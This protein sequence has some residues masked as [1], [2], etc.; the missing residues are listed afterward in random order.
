MMGSCGEQLANT[1]T[2]QNKI[3][4]VIVLKISAWNNKKIKQGNE[5]LNQNIISQRRTQPNVNYPIQ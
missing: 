1:N 3:T 4:K 2:R 5:Q